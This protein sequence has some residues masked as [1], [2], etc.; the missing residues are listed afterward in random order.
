M[1]LFALP[2]TVADL[3]TL[4]SGIQF[5]T[6]TAEA[7]SEVGSINANQP[8]DSVFIYATKLLASNIS[9][10]QVAMAV[11]AIGEGGTVAVGNT[12]TSN[13]LTFL[14]TQF[15]PAQVTAALAGGFDPT[16]YAAQSLGLAVAST[17]GFNA[18][19]AGLSVSQFVG[20]VATATGVNS[21]A[22]QQW[23]TNWTTFFQANPGAHV[24]LTVTQ[25][26]YGATLGNAIG[27]ALLNPTSANLQTIVSTTPNVN[28]FIPNTIQGV[29]ANALINVAEGSYQVGVALGALPAHQFLQGEAGSSGVFLTTGIDSPTSG[30]SNSPSGTPLLNG[31]TATNKGAV[32]NALPV[33]APGTTL[34]NNTLNTGDNLQDTAK[35][36]TLNFTA[37]TSTLGIAANAPFASGVTMNGVET[38]NV[39]NNAVVLGFPFVAGFAGNVTGMTKVNDTASLGTVQ[40]GQLGQGLNT[41]LTN[42]NISGYSP[43][44]AGIVGGTAIFAGI[45]AA[46]AADA[47]KTINVSITGPV[48]TTKAGGADT[49]IFSND[50]GGGTAANPNLSYGTWALTL[51]SNANLTLQQ[52]FAGFIAGAAFAPIA[53]GVG[54]ATA[55]TLAGK[56]NVSLGQDAIGN[57]QLVKNIDAS[58]STGNVII[59]G[60]TSGLFANAFASG[61]N[62]LWLFGSAAGLLDDTGTGGKFNLT[63]Y[64]LSSGTNVLDVSSASAAQVAALTTVPNATPSLTNTIVVKDS[65][66]TTLSATTFAN[67]KGFQ[68]LGIGGATLADGAGGTINMANLPAS[69]GT[70]VYF[71]PASADVIINNQVSALTVDVKDETNPGGGTPVFHDIT[72]GKV[73]PAAGLADSL[74]VS[75]GNPLHVA[76]PYFAGGDL[77]GDITAFGDELFTL[78]SVGGGAVAPGTAGANDIGG[79][80]LVPTPGG[81][82]QVKIT[83]DTT[84]QMAV[85]HSVNGAISS[86]TSTPAGPALLLNNLTVTITNTA[87]T[88]WGQGLAGSALFFQTDAGLNGGKFAPFINYSSNA[89]TIDASASGGLIDPW[90]DANF[91]PAATAALSLGDTIIGAANPVGYQTG[92]A[93][94]LVLGNVFAGSIGNDNL[95]SKSMV[96]PDYIITNGGADKITLA[97]GHTGADH[98]GFYA[99]AG[100]V[101][102]GGAY[103]VGSVTGAISEGGV[104]AFEFANPGWW[105]IGAG[106]S[107]TRIDDF[108]AAPPALFLSP[109]AGTLAVGTGLGTSDSQSTLTNYNPTQDFLDFSVKAWSTAGLIGFGLTADSAGALVNAAPF[110][111]ATGAAVLAAS[112]GP[113]GTIS[114]PGTVD[115]IVLNS[116]T[117]AN[118]AAVAQALAG[119]SYTINHSALGATV[120]ADFLLA[121]QG[122]DGNAHI[123]N[124]HLAG[125][126][127]T[128]TAADLVTVSDMVNLVGVT[129]P[130][131]IAASAITHIHLVS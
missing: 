129:I 68:T 5:F 131:L 42:V 85:T 91:T 119:G 104:G 107:S 21:T 49:L 112:V 80:F 78:T 18:N 6:N 7:T 71:T 99:A 19:F 73:G 38:L 88:E 23:V 3:T 48:G 100:N 83:G 114:G 72:V 51:N 79:T 53:G 55:I 25:A 36:G 125:T 47:T 86:T 14:S 61:A 67:V 110:A 89:V 39:T 60:G 41:L 111:S 87:A 101:N 127:G 37:A 30:F 32:F 31:F 9:L 122:Q 62:P 74:T 76:A 2:V 118:A 108:A 103:A 43:Q 33:V 105:G 109:P 12:T 130:Q 81:N 16:V 96:L 54:G 120:E 64:S 75:V 84:I 4:Q 92:G 13:T 24:G 128:S 22:I 97:A 115:F 11:T 34:P 20:A 82:E 90:G 8:S 15:L 52:D 26:A 58:A 29:V 94:S 27:V 106:G 59:P 35:D 45:V 10:S 113:G 65:V 63:K 70:I 44:S 126:G 69:I 66:A 95:T 40:L 98:V 46:A 50:V 17:A 124:L 77:L 123:A 102:V 1:S 56:G 57:W 116:N 121:Y 117:F 93:G 28:Q